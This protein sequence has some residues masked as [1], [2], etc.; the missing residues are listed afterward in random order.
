[1]RPV[2]DSHT[3]HDHIVLNQVVLLGVIESEPRLRLET[4]PFRLTF[5][6][7]VPAPE[8]VQGRQREDSLLAVVKEGNQAVEVRH[9]VERGA[10]VLVTG[11]LCSQRVAGGRLST[12]V[13][14]LGV[15]PCGVGFLGSTGP[16][17]EGPAVRR[18][19]Q[20][21]L[22][23]TVA[24][25]PEI[26]LAAGARPWLS[27]LMAVRTPAWTRCHRPNF[28]WINRWGNAALEQAATLRQGAYVLVLGGLFSQNGRKG[29]TDAQ[30]HA[31][32]IQ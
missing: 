22:W 28:L 5:T 13:Q 15:T 19:N 21:L 24:S 30:V 32:A 8:W 17:E 25:E 6:L 26:R 7:R 12:W 18:L 11:A 23:G 9:G 29:R 27:F 10:A 4:S 2:N 20:V 31:S 16:V 3:T 1:M 14:A